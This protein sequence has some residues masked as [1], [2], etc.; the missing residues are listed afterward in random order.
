MQILATPKKKT[1]KTL[2]RGNIAM[3]TTVKN[4]T[5]ASVDV[6]KTVVKI[7]LMPGSG[8]TGQSAFVKARLTS[9][10]NLEIEISVAYGSSECFY[11]VIERNDI[12]SLQIINS[13]FVF[14][15][16]QTDLDISIAS[17][18]TTKTETEK[19]FTQDTSGSN[20]GTL[21]NL[22][23]V[24]VNNTTYRIRRGTIGCGFKISSQIIETK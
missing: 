20:V 24:I 11:E 19:S 14:N 1:I 5:I 9:S 15:T 23:H 21:F 6:S 10:T 13:V 2:Q 8:S 18:D 17:V 4:I 16:G 3:S 12:K 7:S 22:G